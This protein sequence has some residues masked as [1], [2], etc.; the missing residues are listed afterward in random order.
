MPDLFASPAMAAGYARARPAV[1]P[2]VI[3]MVWARLGLV[4]PVARALDVG[5]GAGLSTA[6][7][8]R[9]AQLCVGIDPVEA[10]VQSGTGDS[11]RVVLGAARAEALPIAAQSI[12]V[13]TAAGSLN[14]VQLDA[15]FPEALRVL[16]PD[17]ALVVYDFSAGRRF[18][19]SPALDDWFTEFVNRY[20]RAQGAARP[21]DPEAVAVA[22]KGFRMV[23]SERFVV[24]LRL[25]LAFYLDYV[26]TETN[27]SHAIQSGTGA[28]E[29]RS[30]CADS[31]GTVFGDHEHEVLFDGYL[32][33]LTP[34]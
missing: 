24:S 20:P 5:C 6:P 9:I 30:W 19:S 34:V 7:L 33:H 13:V 2:H 14:Y 15:F 10:M 18:R 32:A 11:D 26:M 1:H 21:L 3:E 27:V 12:D 16:R 8:V 28:E 31:L 25:A 22:A 17:G 23:G 4:A 29:I